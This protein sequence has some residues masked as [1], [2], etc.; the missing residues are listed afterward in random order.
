MDTLTLVYGIAKSD[1]ERYMEQLLSSRCKSLADIE[2]VKDAAAKD[3]FHSFRIAISDG[4]APDF[5]RA[6]QS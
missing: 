4:S 5:T 3:G 2:R 6:V 1:T